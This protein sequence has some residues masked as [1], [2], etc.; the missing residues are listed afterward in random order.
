MMT[1]SVVSPAPG[2]YM[3]LVRPVIYQMQCQ[4][5][6][7]RWGGVRSAFRKACG[8][9]TAGTLDWSEARPRRP[10]ACRHGPGGS[11]VRPVGSMGRA[12]GRAAP[13][14]AAVRPARPGT[15]RPEDQQPHDPYAATGRM[16]PLY[17]PSAL[18]AGRRVRPMPL[19]S[20]VLGRGAWRRA[21]VASA[22]T[23]VAACGVRQ[24]SRGAAGRTGWSAG[25]PRVRGVPPLY[26]RCAT[27]VRRV[28]VV[29]HGARGSAAVRGARRGATPRAGPPGGMAFAPAP[30]VRPA[31][32]RRRSARSTGFLAAAVP[33]ARRAGS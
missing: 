21:G 17:G 32:W 3:L 2:P 5:G 18:A 15:R 16:R 6:S 31:I 10:S 23:E 20:G 24:R 13:R 12:P 11:A 27:A 8:F 26:V 29:R 22:S 4:W 1:I 25:R 19:I 28:P 7:N 14:G 30:S 9:R 33:P